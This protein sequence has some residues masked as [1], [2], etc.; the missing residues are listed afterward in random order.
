MKIRITGSYLNGHGFSVDIP[1]ESISVVAAEALLQSLDM[2]NIPTD[3]DAVNFFLTSKSNGVGLD[4]STLS[5]ELYDDEVIHPAQ[6]SR[7]QCVLY[8]LHM[9]DSIN[10]YMANKNGKTK[11]WWDTVQTVDFYHPVVQEAIT[12][13]NLPIETAKGIW[14]AANSIE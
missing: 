6:I 7:L 1:K 13:L 11:I 4:L 2:E 14:R 5:A 9:L 8:D 12:D 3:P 10:Q